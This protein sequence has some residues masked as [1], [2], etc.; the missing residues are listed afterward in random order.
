MPR[1]PLPVGTPGRIFLR[2]LQEKPPLWEG[3]CRFRMADG[4]IRYIH[5]HRPGKT[6]AEN[7]VKS[8]I[9]DLMGEQ[10]RGEISQDTRFRVVCE[11]WID[12]LELD[13][14]LSGKTPSTPR[15]YRGYIRN[16]IAPNL[17]ELQCREIKAWNSNKVIQKAR[18]KSFETA[19]SVRTVLNQVC[20]YAV[21]NGAMDTNPVKDAERLASSRRKEV[22]AMALEQRTE[23]LTKLTEF[24]NAKS[25]DAAGRP[26]GV[27]AQVWLDLP[28]IV[29]AMLST[30]ARLSELM[31]IVGEDVDPTDPTVRVN[32]RIVRLKGQGLVRMDG[33]KGNG[34]GLLLAVPR[35]SVSM[36]RRR[37]IASGGG[38]MFPSSR[39]GWADPSNMTHRI[40]EAMDACGFEWVTSHVWRKTVATVLDE[41]NL[42]TTAIADQL[43]NTPPVVE[44]HY[45]RKRVVNDA[46]AAALEGMFPGEEPGDDAQ[47]R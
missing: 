11:Q 22:R 42:P 7:A 43:G 29:L 14:K 9:S 46:N 31:A 18:D 30:G 1:P 10:T 16:W 8:R 12:N 25:I 5:I 21:R 26:L 35:W 17:G 20:A 19:K 6:K 44:K 4:T 33:R 27:R 13:Y 41:A 36:W 39:G 47:E 34:D 28:D 24:A 3:R 45:R 32:H 15:L 2:Q 37:K 40:R 23:L 38:P